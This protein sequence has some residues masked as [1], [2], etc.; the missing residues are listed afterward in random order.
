[1]Q[2]QRQNPNITPI[3]RVPNKVASVKNSSQIVFG[4]IKSKDAK[5]LFALDLDGTLAHGLPDDLE[6]VFAMK[7]KANAVMVYATGRNLKEFFDLQ[8]EANRYNFRLPLPDFLISNNGQFVYKNI[9]GELV[10][11]EK[12]VSL[13]NQKTGFDRNTVYDTILEVAHRPEY[14]FNEEEMTKLKSL[15]DFELRK[16]EDPHFWDSKISYYEWNPSKFMLE[17]F[18]AADVDVPKL[19]NTIKDEL[20]LHEIKTKFIVN[21]YPKT[22]VDKCD[23]KLIR[24][25]QPMREDSKGGMTAMFSCPANK[26]D[27]VKYISKL[28]K[29]PNEEILTAGNEMNDISMVNMTQN[30]SFFVCVA[31]AVDDLKTAVARLQK[32][33]SHKYSDHLILAQNGGTAGIVEGA[34]AILQKFRPDLEL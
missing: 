4:G 28:L 27:G 1:M 5:A 21:K 16:K 20:K 6:K 22:I 26:A 23:D 3:F 7:E 32:R 2:V 12:W 10:R 19:Q 30:G 31:N 8:K 13:V 11:D 15:E 14:K 34:K 33:P 17:Y 24:Q 29:I 9:S 25:S 18:L